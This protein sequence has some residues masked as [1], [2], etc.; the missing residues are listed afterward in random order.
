MVFPSIL[1]S[2]RLASPFVPVVSCAAVAP[3]VAVVL[4]ATNVPGVPLVDRVSALVS[5]LL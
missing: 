4:S 5:L 2:L 3:L 1:A